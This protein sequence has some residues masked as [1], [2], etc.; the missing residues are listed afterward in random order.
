MSEGGTKT[1]KSFISDSIP[2]AMRTTQTQDLAS[3]K[4]SFSDHAS[5]TEFL[6]YEREMGECESQG[7]LRR[8]KDRVVDG[9]ATF[10]GCGC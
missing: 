1:I 4:H 7:S 2:A 10:L 6:W 3:G 8:N 9:K 5:K